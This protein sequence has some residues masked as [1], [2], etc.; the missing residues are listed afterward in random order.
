MEVHKNLKTQ[1]WINMPFSGSEFQMLIFAPLYFFVLKMNQSWYSLVVLVNLSVGLGSVLYTFV[2]YNFVLFSSRKSFL[3]N[4]QIPDLENEMKSA[5]H[6]EW[7]PKK[8]DGDIG[9][10]QYKW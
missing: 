1:L 3:I 8:E 7:G 2:H 10:R 9:F 6:Q 4:I 5:M